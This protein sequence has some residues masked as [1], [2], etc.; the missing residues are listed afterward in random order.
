VLVLYVHTGPPQN[1]LTAS[2]A[3]YKVIVPRL[4]KRQVV[5]LKDRKLSHCTQHFKWM[6]RATVQAVSSCRPLAAEARIRSQTI[7]WKICGGKSGTR[8]RSYAR[9]SR[10]SIC[11]SFLASVR[12][13]VCSSV[14]TEQLSSHWA[15]FHEIWHLITFQKTVVKN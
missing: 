2:T 8:I 3:Q 11:L 15:D 10:I 4:K 13:S 6:Y 7:P 9:S 14:H 5:P 1:V 12:L